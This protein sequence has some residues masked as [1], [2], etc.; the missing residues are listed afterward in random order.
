[1]KGQGIYAFVTLK[2]GVSYSEELRTGFRNAVR[3]QVHYQ[4]PK[5]SLL[6]YI[7][8]TLFEVLVCGSSFLIADPLSFTCMCCGCAR[9]EHLHPRIRYIGHLHF[10]RQGV[11][12]SCGEFCGKLHRNNS[13]SL[14]IQAHWLILEW[15]KS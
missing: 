8:L 3:I 4:N 5:I 9:L 10:Q 12:R 15:S 7:L 13:T 6:F 14:G 2:E 11:E 1:M